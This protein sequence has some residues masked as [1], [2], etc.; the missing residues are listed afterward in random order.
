MAQAA[1][2]F[3]VS[4]EVSAEEVLRVCSRRTRMEETFR[5]MKWSDGIVGVGKIGMRGERSLDRGF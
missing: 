4:V 1:G 2:W 5:N 3:L